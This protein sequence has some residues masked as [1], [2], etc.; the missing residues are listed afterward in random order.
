MGSGAT[1]ISTAHAVAM[2]NSTGSGADGL[3]GWKQQPPYG[4]SS[5]SFVPRYRA[6]CWCGTIVFEA[7]AD[8]VDSK[9]C[10]CR[11]CQ[12]LHGAP[13]QWAVIFKKQD[14]RFVRGVEALEFFNSEI[15][16]SE[17]VP[18]CKLTCGRCHAP[19]ADEGRRMFLAFG[20]LFNFEEMSDG[21]G[22]IPQSF[23]PT[24]HIFYG[25]R[26]VDINDSLP[27]YEAHKER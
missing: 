7:C 4:G 10:H 19:L 16:C 6:S 9:L 1:L 18:P 23:R 21:N 25:S 22:Q 20:T 14:V 13:M 27:K 8:P 2:T 5:G 11:G 15:G 3:S 12:K 24:C 26:V 17:R